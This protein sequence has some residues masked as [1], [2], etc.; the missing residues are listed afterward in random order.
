MEGGFVTGFHI[1]GF[2]VSVGMLV[3]TGLGS[4][5]GGGVSGGVSVVVVGR[6]AVSSALMS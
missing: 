3:T 4:A 2:S 6:S 5:V 1:G